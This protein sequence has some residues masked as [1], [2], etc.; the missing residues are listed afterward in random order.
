MRGR[1]CVSTISSRPA[2]CP[3]IDPNFAQPRPVVVPMRIKMSTLLALVV[4]LLLSGCGGV[5]YVYS[6]LDWIVPWYADDYVR[7]DEAQRTLLKA[8]LDERLAWHCESEIPTYAR[9]LRALE[10]DLGQPHVSVD[11]L[12]RHVDQATLFWD[13]LLHVL[14]PDI[15]DVLAE[16]NDAQVAELA[17]NLDERNLETRAEFIEPSEAQRHE[18]RVARMEKRLQRWFGRLTP[19][20]ANALGVWS[21]ALEPATEDW[22]A[23]RLRWQG[24]LFEALAVRG[25]REL[26][27]D[28]VAALVMTP[29]AGWEDDYRARVDANRDLTVALIADIHNWATEAQ[30]VRLAN[31][32]ESLVRQL[33]R[34]A[35]A[36]PARADG[37]EFT[38]NALS[39]AAP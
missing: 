19:Q 29:D 22:F 13:A 21:Q 33:D 32:L 2:I 1:A 3:R 16:L 23:Q 36:P 27:N 28:R 12:E 18:K 39:L 38:P 34:L 37:A 35:C 17:V 26:F 15:A 11:T 7:L 10:A 4:V 31:E 14:A 24:Q 20:Q 25:D 8:R 5:R 9:F 6:Q 30:R